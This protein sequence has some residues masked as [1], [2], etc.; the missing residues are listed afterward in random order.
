MK[1]SR[2]ENRL[3][4]TSAGPTSPGHVLDPIHFR[5]H[6]VEQV[7]T[8]ESGGELRHVHQDIAGVP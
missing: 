5:M 8:E 7:P 4:G 3:A 1:I 2:F 6:S